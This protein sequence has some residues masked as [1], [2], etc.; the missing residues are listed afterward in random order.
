MIEELKHR[1]MWV[2]NIPPQLPSDS[3]THPDATV[4]VTS[5]G[6]PSDAPVP[7]TSDG[8]TSD[9]VSSGETFQC[10]RDVEWKD[11]PRKLMAEMG[12]Y[13]KHSLDHHLLKSFANHLDKDLTNKHWKQ[14]VENVSRF[15]YYIDAQ[16]PSLQFVMERVKTQEYIRLLTVAGLSPLTITNYL[17]SVKRFLKYHTVNTELRKNNAVLHADC[18]FFMEF[19][20]SLQTVTSKKVSK[21]ITQQRHER[22]IE[23]NPLT[24]YE[25]CAILRVAFKDFL[26]VIGKADSG[27]LLSDTEL[28]LINYYLGAVIILGHLQPP[29]VVKG[30]TVYEWKHRTSN[31]EGYAVVG[32]KDHKTAVQ[33]VASF[34]LN[35]EQEHFKFCES[36]SNAKASGYGTSSITGPQKLVSRVLQIRA[37]TTRELQEEKKSGKEDTHEEERFFISTTCQPIH[38]PST[39]L[40]V[41]HDKYNIPKINSQK[42]R[43]AFET[44]AA[45][46]AE[47]DSSMV[48]GYLAHSTDMAKKHYRMKRPDHVVIACELL[49][50]LSKG[51]CL[52]DE[53]TSTSST[54]SA[55]ARK[56]RQQPSRNIQIDADAAMAELCVKYPVTVDGTT[57]DLAARSESMF[58]RRMPSERRVDSCIK[59]QDWKSNTPTAKSILPFW[60]PSG[61]VG[62]A[63][64]EGRICKLIENQKWKGLLVTDVGKKGKGVIA[65]RIFQAGEVVCDYHGKVVRGKE[66][67]ETQSNTV[68][69]ETGYMF[70]FSDGHGKR[71]CIDAHSPFCEC[72]P[73]RTTFGRLINHSSKKDNLRPRR[74]SVDVGGHQKQVILLLSTTVI[75]VDEELLFNYGVNKKSHRGEGLDLDWLDRPL[76]RQQVCK[77]SISKKEVAE[78]V[79]QPKKDALEV[80][81]FGRIW[82][83][84]LICKIIFDADPVSS[85]GNPSDAP[86]PVTSDGETS[87]SVSSGETFQCERDVEWKDKPRKLMAEMGLYKKHSLDHHLLKSFANH[88][89]KDLTN[90]HWKQEVENVSRFMYYIDAQE[91]SLQFVMERVKTQEYIRLLTVAGL[92]PLT[93][94]NYLKSMKRFLKYHTV[95][96]ELRKNNAVLHA[97]CKFFMEFIGSLQ[98]VTS[99]KVS[100]VITHRGEL[101]SD[102]ELWLINY[103]LGAVIILG[104]L[105]PPGVVKGMT[106][107]EWKHR[108]SNV[109]GYAV[110]GVKDHKTAVQQ[111]ASFALNPE[112]EHWFHV[113]YKSVRTQLVN[114]KKRKRVEKEDTHEEERFFISTTCQPIHNPST[115][116]NVLHD[117]YNIP[118]INSQKARRAFETAAATLAEKDSSMVAGYLAHSTD[119]A[120]KHYRMKRPD[121]VVIA[122]ELLNQL[123][124][125]VC[126]GD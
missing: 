120:K 105:Q 101:L 30:M 84:G 60:K 28:C 3:I 66:G 122:C 20:G 45:T 89:D 68:D 83:Y 90:K 119:M 38:N 58:R 51:V 24:P 104:H 29:G 98:T 126:L 35:P 102:T 12:L 57:P 36:L 50:Q 78:L 5:D 96:T 118:K 112:Q 107:Y 19:I 97:D 55:A 74:Y 16:E 87:D 76:R 15:M 116:L 33:Q 32:V 1:K 7:V 6:N 86:V 124:K 4:P 31:V 37:D 69:E 79:K 13:K 54:S 77:K 71:M 106:V 11:K 73:G 82:E 108:T 34:A 63:M 99:K 59:K 110:V 114:S 8:E 53:G 123:S 121:H 91:P 46:L 52:G 115:D 25:C 67:Q 21:V 94:T 14:E 41:L 22:L 80:L 81:E 61:S 72:H 10:E 56:D 17:K 103:Y 75:K 70:F 88:L 100:K 117:K 95:N 113:Y 47:K 125:G 93:I 40:N 64:N 111:V 44:A 92:S 65:T 85:D 62:D 49:N 26:S 42:A 109:E 9:S 39:D 2:N 27:E 48:A 18:K 43:R 23:E